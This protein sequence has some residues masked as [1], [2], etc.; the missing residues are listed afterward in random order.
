MTTWPRRALLLV[1]LGLAMISDIAWAERRQEK[2]LNGYLVADRVDMSVVL[3][4]VVQDPNGVEYVR[5]K[6]PLR[7]VASDRRGGMVAIDKDGTRFTGPG[8]HGTVWYCSE[9]A[10]PLI[11]HDDDLP[12]YLLVFGSEGAG[13]TDAQSKWCWFRC[14]ERIAQGYTGQIGMSA[15]VAE[16][17]SLVKAAIIRNWHPSWY[18]WNERHSEF[19]IPTEFGQR[20]FDYQIAAVK[21]AAHH[22]RRACP[23]GHPLLKFEQPPQPLVFQ[24]QFTGPDGEPHHLLK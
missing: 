16:R 5:G 3:H 12:D 21:I 17:L 19:R 13:K 24:F 7:I 18:V 2:E 9:D 15:P 1:A 14:L 6:P 10:R 11:L 20:L 22:L 23:K 8:R 4:T